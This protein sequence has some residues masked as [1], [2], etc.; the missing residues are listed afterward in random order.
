MSRKERVHYRYE[1]PYQFTK[2]ERLFCGICGALW[3]NHT[4]DKAAVTCKRCLARVKKD[5]AEVK[6]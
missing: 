3:C 1:L 2:G 6:P 5:E 4:E